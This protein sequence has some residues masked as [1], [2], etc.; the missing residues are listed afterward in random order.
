MKG[1]PCMDKLREFFRQLPDQNII[2][3]TLSNTRDATRAAKVKLRPVLIRGKVSF[4]ETLYRG[5]QVFHSNLE[6]EE[7]AGRLTGYM[8]SLFGQAQISCAGM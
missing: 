5:T 8:E 3:I 6:K 1:I 4:Q 2:Q 7:L